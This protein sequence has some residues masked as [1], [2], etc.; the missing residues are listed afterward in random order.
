MHIEIH[1]F[2]DS[3]PIDSISWSEQMG[4]LNTRIHELVIAATVDAKSYAMGKTSLPSSWLP[5]ALLAL[6]GQPNEG[7][8]LATVDIRRE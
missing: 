4:R 5:A 1:I 7:M 3:F 8:I 6:D 2:P